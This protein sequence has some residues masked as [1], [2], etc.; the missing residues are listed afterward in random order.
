MST[1]KVE[2][3]QKLNGTQFPLI[4][5][6]VQATQNTTDTITSTSYVTT[7]LNASITPSSSSSK[8]FV[9]ASLT[10]DNN[11]DMRTDAT[12]YRGS[13]NLFNGLNDNSAWITWNTI[14]EGRI[15]A[16]Q[17]NS[18]LDSPST[19]SATTYTIYLRVQEKTAQL[20]G[21]EATST[22]T[23]MEVLA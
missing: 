10:L 3:L 1:L 21:A 13:T 5:Q 4:G 20:M 6:V 18:F 7:S 15:I 14:S 2:N 9:M 16:M 12:L 17:S 23:L 8:I 19:T 22:L 11:S